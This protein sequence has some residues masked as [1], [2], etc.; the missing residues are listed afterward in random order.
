MVINGQRECKANIKLRSEV[1]MPTNLASGSSVL[2]TAPTT[3]HNSIYCNSEDLR[4]KSVGMRNCAAAATI[5]QVYHREFYA[6]SSNDSLDALF[7]SVNSLA[8]SCICR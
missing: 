7:S 5:L 8:T 2:L 6:V 4:Q 1:S 3:A